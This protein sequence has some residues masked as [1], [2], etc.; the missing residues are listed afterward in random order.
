MQSLAEYFRKPTPEEERLLRGEALDM[1]LYQ[2]APAAAFSGK[3]L[4][5]VDQAIMIRPDPGD[6]PALRQDP[7][8]WVPAYL[9]PSGWL[10]IDLDTDVTDWTEVAELIDASYRVTAP[11]RLVR[12]LEAR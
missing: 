9:G 6:E 7:R 12:E 2:P 4:L 1:S 10:G 3:S 8:F 5:P 11:A